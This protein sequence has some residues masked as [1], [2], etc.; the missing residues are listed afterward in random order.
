MKSKLSR[1]EFL[2]AGGLTLL[3]TSGASVFS[4]FARK[5][6]AAPAVDPNEGKR[7]FHQTTIEK[8]PASESPARLESIISMRVF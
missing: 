3:G 6:K 8:A 1:R 2:K 4:R 7:L 5:V